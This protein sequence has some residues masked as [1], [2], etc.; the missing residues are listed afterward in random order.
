MK[1]KIGKLFKQF[2]VRDITS[3]SKDII[4]GSAFFACRGARFN[5]NDYLSDVFKNGASI[6]FTD[7][8]SKEDEDGKIFY[9]K[10]MNQAISIAADII[11]PYNSLLLIG[12]TGTNGKSSVVSYVQQILTILGKK[13][14]CM[15]TLGIEC[16]VESYNRN[17]NNV[18]NSGLTTSDQITFRKSLHNLANH[19]VQYVA[20]EASSHGIDQN[21]IST[22]Q[23]KTAAFTSFSQ[24]HL[25][26]HQTMENYL[27]AKLKLFINNLE[28]NGEAVI[29]VEMQNIEDIIS[30]FK[31]NNVNFK[32]VG[33]NGD[34]KIISNEQNIYKQNIIFEY[35]G[36][37][38]EFTTNII[39]SFQAINL[40][41]AAKLV[42]NLGIDFELIVNILSKLKAVKGRLQRITNYDDEYHIFVD[43]A[44][45]PDA[46]K[47]SLSELKKLIIDNG[48][49]YVVFGCGGD[50]DPSKRIIMGQIASEYANIV[51]ITDDNPRMENAAKIRNEIANGAKNAE[52]IDDRKTAIIQTIQRLNKNDILLIAGKGHEDY[53]II[54]NKTNKFSDIEIAENALN[55][56][57]ENI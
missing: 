33:K 1:H 35:E 6:A 52:I 27:E 10:D 11:Y 15:G 49:L 18:Q 4:G 43:Y 54:G 45:T 48:K 2:D 44:H 36:E 21:R 13:S 30:L 12:V 29:N 55:N 34:L 22:V 51:V 9:V 50:R 20:F 32:T 26:Y 40:I 14:A 16:N 56:K 28:S 41:I 24:D 7:D 57:K 8:K 46:L 19:N 3:T 53:Q 25:E 47:Q 39:G 37:I 5:G 38:Y 42:C 31:L 23:L 17:I